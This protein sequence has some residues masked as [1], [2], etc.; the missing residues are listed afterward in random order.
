VS[1]SQIHYF[2]AVAEEGHLGRAARRLH[3]SQPPLTRQIHNLEDEL[4][5]PLFLRMPK[6]MRL[7]P[8]GEAFLTRARR[9]VSEVEGARA[10]VRN[11]QRPDDPKGS[12]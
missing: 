1:L 2:I 8:A 12:R 5:A 10:A 7:L 9:I 11:I 3:L 4:G 6:G